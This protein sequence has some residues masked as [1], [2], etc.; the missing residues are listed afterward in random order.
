[1]LRGLILI[2][3]GGTL[4]ASAMWGAFNFHLVWTE[5]RLLIVQRSAPSL[6]DTVA[7]VRA[8]GRSEWLKHPH[9]TRSMMGAGH[10]KVIEKSLRNEA[11]DFVDHAFSNVS[12]GMTGKPVNSSANMLS[13]TPGL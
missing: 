11:G 1:M 8:W 12:Q 9:L 7:D 5:D 2:L 6:K 13:A 4:G 3:F 10:K